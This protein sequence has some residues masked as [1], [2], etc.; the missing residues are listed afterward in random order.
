MPTTRDIAEE[1]ANCLWIRR[2]E[3]SEMVDAVDQALRQRDQ[4]AINIIDRFSICRDHDQPSHCTPCNLRHRAIAAIRN[5]KS[6]GKTN[7]D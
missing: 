2:Y 1:L 7:G 4:R 3:F 5:S 6:E